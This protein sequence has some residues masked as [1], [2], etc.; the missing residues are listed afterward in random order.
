M[1]APVREVRDS[2]SKDELSSDVG[3]VVTLRS[4]P[5]SSP[6]ER[7][8]IVQPHLRIGSTHDFDYASIPV[9]VAKFLKGQATRIRQYTGKAIIQIGKDLSAAKHYLSHGQFVRWVEAEVGIPARTAQGYM[10]AAQWASGKSAAVASLPASLLYVLSASNTPK[11]LVEDVLSKAEAGE[12]VILSAVRATLKSLR[13]TKRHMQCSESSASSP[14]TPNDNFDE[15]LDMSNEGKLL[16]EVV[17]ILAS[18]LSKA[19]LARVREIMMS[20]DVLRHPHLSKNIKTAFSAALSWHEHE[21]WN[22]VRQEGLAKETG[23]LASSHA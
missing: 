19:D 14:M 3:S 12:Q 20:D 23:M 16:I 17:R 22:G 13:D 18:A 7:P 8:E 11:E 10:R 5:A 4:P 21:H 9:S 15:H 6:G 1:S 2:Y